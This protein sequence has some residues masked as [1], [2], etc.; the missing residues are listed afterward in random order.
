MRVI[1]EGVLTGSPIS[2]VVWI[3][4]DWFQLVTLGICPPEGL[5]SV[6]GHVKK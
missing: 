6:Y 5:I 2:S 4:Q 3:L 1:K